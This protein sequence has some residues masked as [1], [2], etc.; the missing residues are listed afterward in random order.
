MTGIS[1]C[2]N[3]ETLK[4]MKPPQ[5]TAPEREWSPMLVEGESGSWVVN[6]PTGNPSSVS[7]TQE[8]KGN[9]PAHRE[10]PFGQVR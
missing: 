1:D 9:V 3:F 2:V 10:S 8:S 4:G 7:R 6:H 5:K